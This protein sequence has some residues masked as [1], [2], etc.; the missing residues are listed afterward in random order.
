M[1]Y[2]IH[3]SKNRENSRSHKLSKFLHH[4]LYIIQTKREK[5][6]MSDAEILQDL[7]K[8]FK[9]RMTAIH[10]YHVGEKQRA[11]KVVEIMKQLDQE[12]VGRHDETS[13]SN[14]QGD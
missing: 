4:T 11:E 8:Y 10:E 6:N 5:Y 14:T 12:C 1:P 9:D 13:I 2:T 3:I 7:E